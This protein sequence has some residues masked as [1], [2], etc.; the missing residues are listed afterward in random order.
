ML[1]TKLMNESEI[2]KEGQLLLVGL[3]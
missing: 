3:V 1:K 2:G